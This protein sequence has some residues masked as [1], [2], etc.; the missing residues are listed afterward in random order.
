MVNISFK[1]RLLSIFVFLDFTLKLKIFNSFQN[2]LHKLGN[3]CK[4]II[5][6]PL[7]FED[8]IFG[9]KEINLT[10]YFVPGILVV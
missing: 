7:R 9:K 4:F 6:S 8:P 3:E 2:F 10:D 1:T 5:L